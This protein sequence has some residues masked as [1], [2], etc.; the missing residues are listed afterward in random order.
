MTNMV[1]MYWE[2]ITKRKRDKALKKKGGGF[3]EG[4]KR[5]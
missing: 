4:G 5:V 3:Y 1:G 2:I